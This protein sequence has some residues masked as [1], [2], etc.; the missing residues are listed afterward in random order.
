[1]EAIKLDWKAI[2]FMTDDSKKYSVFDNNLGCS[3]GITAT[4]TVKEGVQPKFFKSRPV[5]FAPRDKISAELDRFERT[6]IQKKS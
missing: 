3:K 6:G 5:P 4:L 1:M 2:H